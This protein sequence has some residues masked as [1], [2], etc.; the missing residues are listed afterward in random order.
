MKSITKNHLRG[1]QIICICVVIMLFGMA[2]DLSVVGA[3]EQP[4]TI[5]IGVPKDRCPIFY[6]DHDSGELVGIGVELMRIAAAEAGY[7]AEFKTIEESSLKE[8]LDNP[9]YDILM[10]FGSPVS[11]VS[12]EKILLSDNLMQTPFV[13]VTLNDHEQHSINEMKIGMLSSMAAA[14][15]TVSEMYP[16]VKITL[17]DSMSDAVKALRAGKV[18]GLMHNSYVWSYVLQKPAYAKL[19][20]QPSA[21]FSMDFRAGAIDT[22]KGREIIERINEGIAKIP[23]TRR[24]A[25]ILDYT[26]RRLY[27]Y[28]FIDFVHQYG[29]IVALVLILFLH[30]VYESQKLRK[31]NKAAE[32]ASK[33]KTM[34]LANM[35]HEIRTPLNSIMG[36]GELITRETQ[37]S[38][39][40]QYAFSIK[41]SARSLLLLVNDILD[42]SRME[43]GR[44]KL[45]DDIYHLSH[46]LTDVDMVIKP[47]AESKALSYEVKIDPDTPDVLVGDEMRLKQVLI[48]LLT[49]GVKYT[50]SGFVRL[51]IGFEKVDKDSI[52]LKIAVKDSGMG[53]KQSEIA[54]LFKAFE[55]LD[56]DKNRTIEGTGLGMSIV[57]TI[58]DA[59]DSHLDIHSVYGSGSEFSFVL[60]QKVT[61]WSRIGDYEKTAEKIVS[62]HED[63][64]PGFIA[65]QV[66]ILVV[67]DTELNLKVVSGLLEQTQIQVDTALSGK[68]ALNCLKMSEYDL[69][70]IDYRM[71][72]MDGVEL[73]HRI[74]EDDENPNHDKICIALTA[75]VVEGG[76]QMYLDAGFDEYLEKPINSKRLEEALMCYLPKEKL[77]DPK[78]VQ[79]DT[80]GESEPA[81]QN[82]ISEDTLEALHMLEVIGVIDIDEG[83]EYA[84][85]QELYLQTLRFFRD[86]IDQKSDEIDQMYNEKNI[87]DYTIRV[88]GLKS[89][90]KVIGA[91]DLS[92]KAKLMEMAGKRKDWDYITQNNSDLLKVYRGY[93]VL[94]EKI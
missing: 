10:P 43:A 21:F 31:A 65:P 24:Q 90:A 5:V 22:K 63:Y 1:I 75:N 53:M 77:M 34:F 8:A 66:R 83:I 88:H 23:D 26:T 72:E 76:R 13:L 6:E 79:S 15:E 56:E 80:K 60:R 2:R 40:Q 67:D 94:L 11:S 27:R 16:D 28:S 41:S 54:K 37:D 84:G 86:V 19:V 61:D 78:Q 59:M 55:R 92:E 47:R 64:R 14:A 35:S 68:Q 44:L 3:N 32:E 49:N 12:G 73:L 74:R 48:N 91:M 50:K 87:E 38:K 4:D 62:R 20:V 70:L 18:D 89:S 46:L 25:V 51:M 93:K 58:L 39:L 52:D 30:M 36:M 42:F 69:L 85:S 29:V 9:A 81:A 7:E 33:A 17:Y 71:P 57:K 82:S 45:I